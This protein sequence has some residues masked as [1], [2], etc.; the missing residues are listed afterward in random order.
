MRGGPFVFPLFVDAAD[1][2][3]ADARESLHPVTSTPEEIAVLFNPT[4]LASLIR[5]ATTNISGLAGETTDIKADVLNSLPKWAQ[6]VVQ[7]GCFHTGG[8]L[9]SR[10]EL[11]IKSE[12]QIETE[13]WKARK[14]RSAGRVDSRKNS[15]DDTA[16]EPQNNSGEVNVAL[17]LDLDRKDDAELPMVST[18]A[19]T[20]AESV[21]KYAELLK[22]LVKEASKRQ[23]T[24]NFDQDD[25]DLF[26]DDEV[27]ILLQTLK[28]MK[29][30]SWIYSLEP[31]LLIS[32][33]Q[34][35]DVQV[36]LG[37]AVDVI[38]AELLTK[39]KDEELN[40]RVLRLSA[41]LDIA[42]CELI[43]INSFQTD[44]RILSEESIDSCFQLLHH[45]I[46]NFLLPCI[47][48]SFVTT[49]SKLATKYNDGKQLV[50]RKSFGSSR[51]NLCL[52]KGTRRAV[53]RISHVVC[54]FMDNLATLI[55]SIKLADRWILRL[56]SSMVELFALDHSSYAT[57]LQQSALSILR[58]IFLRYKSHRE[59]LFENIVDIMVKLPTSK[60]TFKTVKLSNSNDTVQRISTLVV[61]LVQCRVSS[62]S[63]ETMETEISWQED[64]KD[65][66]SRPDN[67]TEVKSLPRC[68]LMKRLLENVQN[69]ARS[70]VRVFLRACWKNDDRYNRMVLDNFVEDLLVMFVRPEW[71]GAEDLLKALSSSL[72][73]ILHANVSG[74]RNSDHH[75][76]LSALNL[77]G[78]VCTSIKG[79]QRKVAVD[80]L[81]DDKG[82][83]ALIEEHASCLRAVVSLE[84][85][86]CNEVMLRFDEEII[87]ELAL[88]HIV[89][90][91][92]QRHN[93]DEG[94]SMKLLILKFISELE[95]RLKG[96]KSN[97]LEREKR[98]WK[99][100]WEGQTRGSDSM[101][102]IAPPTIELALKS[103]L[104]LAVKRE[105][106][107]LF[108][109]LLAHIMI[110]LS[111]G[112]P[113]LKARVMKCLRGIVDMDPMLMTDSRV[114]LAVKR[115]CTD[116]KPS[117]REAAVDLIGS[118]VSQ[119]PLLNL[120]IWQID[121]Y[122][123]VLS[124]RIR[125]K[126]MKV[127]KSVC[128]IFKTAIVMRDRN[129]GSITEQELR[130][131]SACMRCL[132]ERIGHA[133]E[134]RA[135]KDFVIDIFQEV[136]FGSELSSSR[137]LNMFN[138]EFSL[139]AGWTALPSDVHEQEYSAAQLDNNIKFVS[140]DGNVAHS[141]EEAWSLAQTPTVT[142]ASIVKTNISKLDNSADVV[143]TIVEVL[144]GVPN[145]KWF[146]ELLKRLLEECNQAAG[147][148]STQYRLTH[149]AIARNRSKKIVDRLVNNLMDLQEGKLIKGVSIDKAEEQFAACMTALSAFCEANPQ[150]LACHLDTIRVY[151]KEKDIRVQTSCVSIINNVLKLKRV[152][153]TIAM[154]LEDDLKLL[155]QRSSP[156][157][158]GPSI[159]CLATL[160]ITRK[161]APNHLFEMLEHYFLCICKYKQRDSYAGLSDQE[162]QVLQRALF[163]AGKIVGATD[164]DTCVALSNEAKVLTIGQITEL[165]YNLYRQ[166]VQMQGN[167]TCAGK[168]VQGM[169]F[170]FLIRPRLFLRAQQEGL[171][172]YLL[173]AD[174]RKAKLQ[175]LISMKELLLYQEEHL[176]NG[177]ATKSLNQFKSKEQQ[178]QGDQEADASLIGNVMQAE[179]EN[180]LHLLLQKVPQIRKAAIACIDALLT[181]GL[182]NPLQCIPNL[183]ALETD[184][185]SD[186]RDTA[187][188]L[189]LALHKR[190]W[191]QFHTPLIEGIENSYSFQLSVFGDTTAL[192]I[193]E[194]EKD[195]C[196]FGR[197]F[198]NCV[199]TMK[200]H[201]PR[202]LRALVNQFT[203]Q[204]SILRPLRNK[205]TIIDSDTITSRLKF[206]CYLAQ[207][208]AS[209]PYELE[210]EPLYIIYLVNRY[211][212][213]RLGPVM[214]DLKKAFAEAGVAPSLLMNDELD[215]ST[216]K[217]GEY[218]L[219][220][221]ARSV[222][223]LGI[224]GRTAF[225]IAL[226]LRL[227]F[228]LKHN[229]Q[230]TNERCATFKPTSTDTS[231]EAKER[232]F[233]KLLLP[234]VDDL[235]HANDPILINWNLFMV[236][237]YAAREDQKQLDI[238]LEEVQA[239]VPKQRRQ[240][241][242]A[243]SSKKQKIRKIQSQD[244]FV[245]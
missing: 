223:S 102:T 61:S 143:A 126:G 41:S 13:Y 62:S 189:L 169:G 124:E 140:T 85:S 93:L 36:R 188:S 70:F 98:V 190:Y 47:D 202:F 107:G 78:K 97:Y 167:D 59:L 43:L 177:H 106:C 136:W 20:T 194:N 138:D 220:L 162:N 242:R 195:F 234:S 54:E 232:L 112:A 35:F 131:K 17:V 207:I 178:V 83:R 180:V 214:D 199:P 27:K 88:K 33:I 94:D 166:F 51:L 21:S 40:V 153:Y 142:P 213:L 135:I 111:K 163:V 121:E 221:P 46:R 150:L 115:C 60:R 122:F 235:C 193:D 164:I 8:V 55:T 77:I 114:Q 18:H 53:E 16:D 182:V 147:A 42:I 119:Q 7:T 65:V 179:L 227:K 58:G 129:R 217:L 183:V 245:E 87:S 69:D 239:A 37:L 100:L 161:S 186:V 196:L 159:E 30:N 141:A 125:D 168:A 66:F 117:V 155:V 236:A 134:D 175:C 79:Y 84:K 174:T 12:L 224:N 208:L 204:G 185:I 230:L 146:T 96:V 23:L 6:A 226:M 39:V 9:S 206:L 228:T 148:H 173:K 74:G 216:L 5:V 170:L 11:K 198:S 133:A 24:D 56:S 145:L 14:Q 197:L 38:S 238:D 89:V 73:S 10:T 149:V 203:E 139:P 237:W 152:P 156:S 63:F 71:V 50:C 210:E 72:A 105:F 75:Q 157:V 67:A 243:F 3:A 160:S 109:K 130:R 45:A 123:G 128:K 222:L 80:G 200:S 22:R 201:R 219:C 113:F 90:T 154:K 118:Y 57:S 120:L 101:F 176:G 244:E 171:L 48:T 2:A 19:E 91:H 29:K 187:F 31:D 64:F 218:S 52:M 68:D 212:S 95:I 127:R 103:Y 165:L 215:L 15:T 110:L 34:A 116:E 151:L 132:V 25:V 229:F 49:A 32:L 192:G 172:S 76:S 205:E 240:S 81:D 44:R 4:H 1:A 209:L 26:K 158:V 86:Q 211:V 181:Q 82:T 241:R 191:S 92:L 233:K 108:S 99:S 104:H 137:S 231:A 144:H 28:S 184:R 225:A